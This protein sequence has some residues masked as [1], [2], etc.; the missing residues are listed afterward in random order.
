MGELETEKNFRLFN[1][2]DN[3]YTI[4]NDNMFTTEI[5]YTSENIIIVFSSSLDFVS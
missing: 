1:R 3:E 2:I 5:Q 4:L